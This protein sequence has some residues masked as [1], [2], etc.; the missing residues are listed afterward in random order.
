M[1]KVHRAKFGNHCHRPPASTS[2][3]QK[4]E[5]VRMTSMGEDCNLCQTRDTHGLSW[6]PSIN[7]NRKLYQLQTRLIHKG[8]EIIMRGQHPKGDELFFHPMETFYQ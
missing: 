6:V 5:N 1:R 3:A 4:P 7:R 2:F 8:R